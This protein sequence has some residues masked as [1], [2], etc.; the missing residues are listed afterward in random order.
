MKK[1]S[2]K[3][4][5]EQVSTKAAAFL[6]ASEYLVDR[7]DINLGNDY[8]R[9]TVSSAWFPDDESVNVKVVFEANEDQQPALK[10]SLED[11]DT[12]DDID[13]G[14]GEAFEEAFSEIYP[15][16]GG[17]SIGKTSAKVKIVKK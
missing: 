5:L 15:D 9:L 7:H 1:N 6:T 13:S 12:W 4:P 14:I 8:L 17:V 3:Y 11:E 10:S 16:A 2:D